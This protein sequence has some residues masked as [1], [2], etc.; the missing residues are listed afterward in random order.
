MMKR[1]PLIEAAGGLVKHHNGKILFIYR[2]KKWDLPKG[3]IEKKEM[4]IDGAVREVME[5]TGVRDLIVKKKT[6]PILF[7]FFRETVIINSK[8]P[9]GILM[10]TS[11]DGILAPQLDEGI[12]LAAWKKKKEIP[13]LMQNAYENIKLLLKEIELY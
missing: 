10:T 12:A 4:L 13:Q 5:E 8:K 1:F 7:I 11:Y 9:T 2:N 3:R 6:L